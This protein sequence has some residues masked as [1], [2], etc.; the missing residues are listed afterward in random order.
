MGIFEPQGRVE[1]QLPDAGASGIW[2]SRD[3]SDSPGEPRANS[4]CPAG[5]VNTVTKYTDGFQ[6][7]PDGNEDSGWCGFCFFP[8]LL[9]FFCSS[10]PGGGQ[11]V[12]RPGSSAMIPNLCGFV[13]FL[14]LLLRTLLS[15]I[16]TAQPLWTQTSQLPAQYN[17]ETT[18]PCFSPIVSAN[19]WSIFFNSSFVF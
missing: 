15:V 17:R 14:A 5:C 13:P 3:H 18:L 19:W 8:S 2:G 1:R 7:P 9:I 16:F 6:G 12:R 11:N 4:V 10:C